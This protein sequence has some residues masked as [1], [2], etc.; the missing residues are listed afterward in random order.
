MPTFRILDQAPQF[1]LASGE[2]NAG[3]SLTF[4]ETD[5]STLKDTWSDQ[6]KTTL[7]SNPVLLDAAGRSATDIWGD[8][9]YGV[10]LKDALGVTIWTRNNVE[11][12][13]GTGTTIPALVSGQ[14]LSND[15]SILQWQPILQVPDPTGLNNYVLT[16]D[17]VGAVWQQQ[18]D[19]TVPDPDIVVSTGGILA[20][21]ST[22]TN[23]FYL[24]TGSGTASAS[25]SK[26]ASVGITFAT[27]FSATPVH[28]GIQ[29]TGGGQTSAGSYVHPQVTAQS[30]TGFTAGF[31]TLT[32]GTSADNQSPSNITSAINFTWVAIGNR[33]VS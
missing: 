10:V 22:D 26:T 31:S 13:G 12:P 20:G 9:E 32:G 8:G 18:T 6:A 23:K 28:I 1:F 29:C 27:P 25:G 17:G 14:F 5:L 16:S 30:A 21:V 19:P 2:V 3:G 24:E 15:G 7:N 33:T 4:Y 11:I